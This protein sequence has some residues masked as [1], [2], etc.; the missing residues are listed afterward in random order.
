MKK[1][2]KIIV[3]MESWFVAQANLDLLVSSNPPVL[4]SPVV[5]ITG[6]CHYAWLIFIFLVEMGFYH[7]GQAGL[8][9]LTSGDS[10][11]SAS[12]RKANLYTYDV[13]VEAI[14]FKTGKEYWKV[15]IGSYLH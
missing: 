13:L 12:Q 10:P 8:K 14:N 11:A 5:R 9:L 2:F 3:E 6:T 4:A 1:L 7:I 15:S